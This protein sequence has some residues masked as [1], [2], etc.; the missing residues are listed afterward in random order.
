MIQKTCE[1][2]S[3]PFETKKKHQRFCR[4]GCG[5]AHGHAA[6]KVPEQTKTCTQCGKTFEVPPSGLAKTVC[7]WEC[8]L[9]RLKARQE[10]RTPERTR[11]CAECGAEFRV[12]TKASK[13][14]FCR[15][16]C[17]AKWRMRVP[18]IKAKVHCAEVREKSAQARRGRKT[19]KPAWNRGRPW[20]T[21]HRAKMSQEAKLRGQRPKVRGGNG[22]PLPLPVL[23][24]LTVLPPHVVTEFAIP[25][26]GRLPGYPTCYKVDIALVEEKVAIEVD[27]PVHSSRRRL[28]AK[29]DA[30]LTELGWRVL[31]IANWEAL[32]MFIPS[33][34]KDAR[35]SSP[36]VTLSTIA[37]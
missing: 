11:I 13:Q 21:E 2:C 10:A 8:H 18:E 3:K 1:H 22:R 17:S 14:R 26:G 15:R 16:S 31:R 27:G 23:K 35:I 5:I 6:R 34:S 37:A 29:K 33:K 36:E 7:S 24:L 28:D 12:A 25:L 9:E 4:P 19:G 32:A 20:P 30:K